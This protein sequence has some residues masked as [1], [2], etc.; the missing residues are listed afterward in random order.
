VPRLLRTYPNMYADLSAGSGWNAITRDEAY[1]LGFQN[2]LQDKLLFGT[3]VCYADT[4]GRMPQLGYLQRLRDEGSLTATAYD[5]IVSGNGL[6]L[7][8]MG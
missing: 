4:Q 2:A 5:K 6:R 3:D 7:L 1:G 8:G